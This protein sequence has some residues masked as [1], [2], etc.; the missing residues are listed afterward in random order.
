MTYTEA[1]KALPTVKRENL[2]RALAILATHPDESQI[3]YRSLCITVRDVELCFQDP[4]D[5]EVLSVLMVAK[6][7]G[8]ALSSL[9]QAVEQLRALRKPWTGLANEFVRE[10][11]AA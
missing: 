1:Q 6:E 5:L 8:F 11:A 3:G 4:D 9:D 10:A 2:V 7:F